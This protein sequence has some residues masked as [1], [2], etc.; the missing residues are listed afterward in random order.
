LRLFIRLS[1]GV[2][3]P[4]S[5][6]SSGSKGACLIG[7]EVGEVVGELAVDSY[8]YPKK[9]P[10]KRLILITTKMNK[11]STTKS[12]AAVVIVSL[13]SSSFCSAAAAANRAKTNNQNDIL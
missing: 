8:C 2:N 10:I 4:S 13:K 3:G 5:R 6:K 11:L 12:L 7:D 1:Q 9:N